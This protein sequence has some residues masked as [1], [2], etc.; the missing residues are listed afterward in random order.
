MRYFGVRPER[1]VVSNIKAWEGAVTRTDGRHASLVG[2]NRFL[3]YEVTSGEVLLDWVQAYF[4]SPQGTEA[5]AA[6]SPGSADRNR[7]LSIKTFE[8]IAIPV[9]SLSVQTEATAL[10]SQARQVARLAARA[11]TVAGALL[12]AARNEIFT[13]M[14]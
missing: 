11:A 14:R 8:E 7:T 4:A 3:Q 1:L 12:P 13:A 6:A 10:I 2:S 9:P 5:L